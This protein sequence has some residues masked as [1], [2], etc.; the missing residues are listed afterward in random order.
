MKNLLVILLSFGSLN[1]MISKEQIS[2]VNKCE[3]VQEQLNIT[4]KF[5]GYDD[6]SEAYEFN[7]KEEE[8]HAVIRFT[9]APQALIDKFSLNSSLNAGK[10][11]EISYIK[12]TIIQGSDNPHKI[13]ILKIVSL[14]LK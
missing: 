6:F 7:Y 14:A 11:F 12:K 1:V 3:I 8:S 9:E 2:T 13:T 10:V 5:I 4:A